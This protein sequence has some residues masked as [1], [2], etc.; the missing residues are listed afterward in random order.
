MYAS[1]HT[2]QLWFVR[3]TFINLNYSWNAIHHN[4]RTAS[5]LLKLYK[6]NQMRDNSQEGKKRTTKPRE[7]S[8]GRIW[9]GNQ[10]RLLWVWIIFIFISLSVVR[11]KKKL[12]KKKILCYASCPGL[13]VDVPQRMSGNLVLHVLTGMNMLGLADS[14]SAQ[15]P[16]DCIVVGGGNHKEKLMRETVRLQGK[17]RGENKTWIF[18]FWLFCLLSYLKTPWPEHSYHRSEK[19][20]II[21]NPFK[22]PV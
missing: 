15:K 1:V 19:K 22:R 21:L 12:M 9:R 5:V 17:E 20:K 4:L 10:S 13:E 2:K 3:Q 14:F 7:S 8:E 11:T 18:V 16:Q 6:K